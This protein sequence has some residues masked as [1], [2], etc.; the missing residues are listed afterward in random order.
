VKDGVI[1]IDGVIYFA[2]IASLLLMRINPLNIRPNAATMLEQMREGWDYVR[3]FR[4]I[5]TILLLFC[6][7]QPDGLPARGAA[8]DLRRSEASRRCGCPLLVNSS[9]RSRCGYIGGFNCGQ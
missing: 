9:I 2:V 4:P 6:A 5:R 8:V 3:M 7:H 1:L